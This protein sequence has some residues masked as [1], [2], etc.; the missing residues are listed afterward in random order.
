MTS[1]V[2]RT[3]TI[4]DSRSPD[5]D[6][7]HMDRLET[8]PDQHTPEC[9]VCGRAAV[10]IDRDDTP[11]CAKHAAIFVTRDHR[12]SVADRGRIVR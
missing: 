8:P 3:R 4:I 7:I 1:H 2:V 12:S 5:A 11:M 6:P 10:T 9:I